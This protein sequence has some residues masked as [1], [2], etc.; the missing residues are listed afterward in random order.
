MRTARITASFVF[1]ALIAASSFGQDTA[2]MEQ[3]VGTY[4]AA[5]RFMGTALVARG[6][7]VILSKGFGS[8][9]LEWDIPNS[10]TTKFR[11]GSLTK[12]FTAASILLL[13]ERGKL[14]VEDPVKKYLPDAPAA[15][16]KITIFNLLTHTSGIPNFTGFPEYRSLQP[17]AKTTE[18][19]V[20]VFR[21]KP[22]DFQP[23]EKWSYSN[24]GYV[25][26]GYLIEKITGESYARFVQTNIF[27][28]LGMKDSGYDSNAAVIAHRASGYAPLGSVVVNAGF[29]HMSV[30]HAAGALYSTTEDLL[31][32][33]QGLFGGKLLPPSSLQKMTTPYKEDYACGLIVRTVNGRR[34]FAHNGG[35][36]GFN[37]FLAYYPDEKLTIA[38]LSN[39]NGPAA[40]EIARHLTK[41]AH[42]ETVILPQDRKA[43]ALARG[44]LESYVGVYELRPAVAVTISLD[45]EQL[46][47]QL[48]GQA[49][50]PMYPESPTAFFL[51][52]VDA[53][54]DFAKDATGAVTH[55]VLHQ[56]GRDQTAVRR[57]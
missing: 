46:F 33:E 17:F 3:V 14:K 29:I 13:E 15:W 44:E 47:A 38:V 50:T 18:Q 27:A 20:A 26:L 53:Q 40:E 54:I 49:K 10:P 36:E 55:L 52:A 21:D 56:N 16:D 35:I 48:T 39:V 22:L 9:N 41:L 6:S 2:R 4:V 31:R 42:G 57:K 19:L 30:P 43:I 12:Q 28:P 34:L 32:W 8:A 25:L 37:T 5:K 11:L 45:G 51:T 23:D 7:D 1:A 24:S